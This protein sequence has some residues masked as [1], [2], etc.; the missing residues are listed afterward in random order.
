MHSHSAICELSSSMLASQ[1]A[2]VDQ[3]AV[4]LPPTLQRDTLIVRRVA[5]LSEKKPHGFVNVRVF[6]ISR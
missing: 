1:L 4:Q 6:L 2:R 5:L 3:A